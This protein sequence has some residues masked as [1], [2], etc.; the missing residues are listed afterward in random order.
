MKTVYDGSELDMFAACLSLM[1]AVVQ[2][3]LSELS[4]RKWFSHLQPRVNNLILD[5]NPQFILKLQFRF[6]NN[7]FTSYD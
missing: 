6:T 2:V 3:S 7:R 5:F 1:A 4:I